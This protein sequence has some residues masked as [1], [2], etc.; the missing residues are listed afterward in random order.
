MASSLQEAVD[1]LL[2]GVPK[3]IEV[4]L[5]EVEGELIDVDKLEEG[6]PEKPRSVGAEPTP[7][8]SPSSRRPRWWQRG[9]S[10]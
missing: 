4:E 7:P 9:G 8:P 5:P 1:K 2:P 6:E 3:G 10:R